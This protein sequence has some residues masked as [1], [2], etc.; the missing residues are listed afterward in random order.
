MKNLNRW[1]R[2][3]AFAFTCISILRFNQNIKHIFQIGSLAL[4]SESESVCVAWILFFVFVFAAMKKVTFFSKKT[5][6]KKR[7]KKIK[8]IDQWCVNQTMYKDAS[9]RPLFNI[10]VASGCRRCCDCCCWPLA[11]AENHSYIF[12]YWQTVTNDSLERS[13]IEHW[14]ARSMR[15]SNR[16]LSGNSISFWRI[17]RCVLFYF[18]FLLQAIL[19]AIVCD[20]F[21]ASTVAQEQSKASMRLMIIFIFIAGEPSYISR[22]R[23]INT[24]IA[25]NTFR[26]LFSTFL[27]LF[28]S[29]CSHERCTW[30]NRRVN[31]CALAISSYTRSI[32]I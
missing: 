11:V 5:N 24:I 14:V 26:S 19:E 28:S 18:F 17:S 12:V 29:L 10:T 22:I 13:G 15:G 9:R 23:R 3:V 1:K 8:E 21:N 25:A 2:L 4:A 7:K 27:T 16:R 20:M 6:T 31:K 30:R 32:S